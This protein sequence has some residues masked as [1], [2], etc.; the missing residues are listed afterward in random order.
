[1]EVLFWIIY[2]PVAVF[3]AVC[4]W[5]IYAKAGAYGWGCIVPIYNII[6]LCDIAN[7]SRWWTLLYFVPFVN[8]VAY[9]VLYFGVAKSF[10]RGDGF[11]VGLVFLPVVFLPIL[12]F[13]DS[14]Y[15]L[16]HGTVVAGRAPSAYGTISPQQGVYSPGDALKQLAQVAKCPFCHSTTFRVE[17]EAGLRR[18]SDCHSVL[19]N[20]IQGSR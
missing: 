13:G 10:G 9:I 1:M 15:N 19:P 11:A 14:Q 12:A 6:L 3:M 7:R 5:I 18:C 17:E 2:I 8:I 16:R 4:M 20:Y